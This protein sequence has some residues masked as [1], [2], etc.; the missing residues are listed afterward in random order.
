MQDALKEEVRLTNI[1]NKIDHEKW[2]QTPIN[3]RPQV[4]LTVS[5]DMGWQKRSSGKRYDSLSGHAFMIGARSKKIIDCNV[6]SKLCMKCFHAKRTNK[7]AKAHR[8][9][10]NYDAS[11]KAMEADAALQLYKS[12]YDNSQGTIAL[13]SIVADDDSSMRAKLRHKS[14]THKAG[15]LPDNIP[16]PTWLA[17]PSHRCKVVAKQIFK[18]AAQDRSTTECTNV[19]AF[20]IKKYY[21]YA[22]KMNRNK[23]LGELRQAVLNIVE[24]LFGDHNGCDPQWCKPRKIQ[25]Q[26]K[27]LPPGKDPIPCTSGFYRCKVKNQ[28]L[29]RQIN[30]CMSKVLTDEFLCQCLHEFDTQKNE[31]MNTSVNKYARKGRT[32]CT[33]TSLSNRVMISLGVQNYG[34]EKFWLSVYDSLSVSISPALRKYLTKKDERKRGKNAYESKRENKIKR[35]KKT[36]EKIKLEIAKAKKD[37]ARGCTYGS[38]IAMEANGQIPLEIVEMEKKKKTA[39]SQICPFA[40]CYG[41]NHTTTK[42]KQCK[43]HACTNQTELFAA[44]KTYL[45]ECYPEYY[46]GEISIFVFY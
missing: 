14:R 38:G 13:Q 43:Y 6:S 16:E 23:T 32:Y 19:D 30:E 22:V 26:N 18:L 7:K 2:L 29:Y 10:K 8:C 28:R 42:S 11:S 45:S 41:R 31:G 9:P 46:E 33:S 24:H 40:G 34:Y 1:A 37:A 17:D 35:A 4:K 39:K 5:F 12:L 27:D 21:G 25:L 20:R 3:Q 44:I 15:A 36:N